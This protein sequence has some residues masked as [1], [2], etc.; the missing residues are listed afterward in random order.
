[1]IKRAVRKDGGGV[2]EGEFEGGGAVRS[3]DARGY[4]GYRVSP[5]GKP[6]RGDRFQTEGGGGGGDTNIKHSYTCVRGVW[7]K[8]LYMYVAM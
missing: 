1:M 6:I 8:K 4:I 3:R 5:R 7:K 2:S